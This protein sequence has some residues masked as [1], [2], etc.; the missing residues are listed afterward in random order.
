MKDY[1]GDKFGFL[2]SVYCTIPLT[3]VRDAEENATGIMETEQQH[4]T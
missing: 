1:K 4:I 2:D 3:L